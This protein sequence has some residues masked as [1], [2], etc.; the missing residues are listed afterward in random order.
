MR[1]PKIHKIP[2]EIACRQPIVFFDGDCTLC[3][4]SVQFLLKHNHKGNLSFAS[5]Q[6]DSGLTVLSLSGIP[7]SETDTLLLLQDNKVFAYS[8]A[9]LKISAHLA[10]PWRMFLLFRIIPIFLRDAIY[11]YVAL[12]RYK[13][14]GKES[15]CI[16]GDQVNRKRFLT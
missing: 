3:S 10:F 11:K 8:T 6:S 12:N 15:Y 5:L 1:N 16:S 13:W 7:V 4:K 9:A 2:F 14:F